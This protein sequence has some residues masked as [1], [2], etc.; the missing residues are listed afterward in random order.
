MS[1]SKLPSQLLIKSTNSKPTPKK[2][3]QP[4]SIY[5]TS[6]RQL[7]TN[8]FLKNY[9][10]NYKNV[11][12]FSNFDHIS[13]SSPNALKF[14]GSKDLDSLPNFS[15]KAN[16]FLKTKKEIVQQNE[17]NFFTKIP[18]NNTSVILKER[19]KDK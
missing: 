19:Q 9:P 14:I 6:Q 16:L 1:E 13:I 15:N 18:N 11:S 7:V 4:E 3:I 8:S 10:R 12:C 17:H 2:Q 5:R